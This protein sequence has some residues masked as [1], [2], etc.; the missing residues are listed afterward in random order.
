MKRSGVDA[1]VAAEQ[2]RV[3]YK[4]AIPASLMSLLIAALVCLTLLGITNSTALAAWFG[5]LAVIAVFRFALVRFFYRRAPE[6]ADMESWELWFVASVVATSVVWGVGGLVIM[7]ADSLVH[8]M[9]VYFFLMAMAGAALASYSAHPTSTYVTICLVLLPSTAWFVAQDNVILRSMAAGALVSMIAAMRARLTLWTFLRQS[10]QVSHE[11]RIASETAERLARTDEL[12]GM[13]N[14]RAFY[15]L[16]Q[17]AFEQAQRYDR[18]LTVISIDID[19]FKQINEMW[20]RGVGDAAL[21]AMARVITNSSRMTDIAGRIGGEEFAILLPETTAEAAAIDAERLRR[22]MEA[23]LVTHNNGHIQFTCSIGVASRDAVVAT[24][25]MLM[26]RA[27]G[28]L[29]EAKGR[30]RN[31]VCESASMLS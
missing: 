1:S 11:L 24:L 23:T 31:Q 15:E 5:A 17:Q 19:H 18:P 2:V 25:D 21:R 8:Q 14:R 20:G 10:C 7:P 26:A 13:K 28:A 12:T 27:D 9:V 4:Q 22:E 3:I 29:Y 30:G 6:A 16:A